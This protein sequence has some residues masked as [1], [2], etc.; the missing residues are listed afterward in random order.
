MQLR[1]LHHHTAQDGPT[2]YSANLNSAY[3]IIRTGQLIEEARRLHGEVAADVVLSACDLGFC[4]RGELRDRALL[5]RGEGQEAYHARRIDNAIDNLIDDHF[6][7]HLRKAHF[8]EEHDVRR[9]VE[10][11]ILS[12]MGIAKL[13]GTKAKADHQAA[14][15]RAY[16]EAISTKTA[17]HGHV[18]MQ[19]FSQRQNEEN[20]KHAS[21]SLANGHASQVNTLVQP[22]LY[23]VVE[24]AQIKVVTDYIRPIRGAGSA[25]I[26]ECVVR[27]AS[28]ANIWAIPETASEVPV[29]T[30]NI[31]ELL[32]NVNA[33]QHGHSEAHPPITNGTASNADA[34]H[35]DAET[36]E[37]VE[38]DDLE[39]ELA[40][41]SETACNCWLKEEPGSRKYVVHKGALDI[42]VRKEETLRLLDSR[43]ND[44]GPRILRILIDK[45]KLEERTLQ[46]L[47]LLDAKRLRQSLAA[48]KQMGYVELQ[49]VPRNPTRQPN[50]TVFLWAYEQGRVA[51]LTLEH[52]YTAMLRLLQLL[53]LERKKIHSTLTKVERE[54]VKGREEEVL[55][56]AEYTVLNRFRRVESWIWAEMQRLDTSVAILRD[57]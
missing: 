17:D 11:K 33:T 47:G 40:L 43:L 1:L 23:K 39:Y 49:E 50:M 37:E 56:P 57:T 22:N 21:S 34:S 13:S 7:T 54:D 53:K 24:L 27:A 35:H 36:N 29:H 6:L 28:Y 45:G 20:G 8:A 32:E 25:K 48:L 5:F 19:Y 2:V 12:P 14:V 10:L 38:I 9:D 30:L 4:T 55:G 3:D 18:N 44:P 16:F 31:H 42:W 51:T 26:A 46:E 41:L 15:D 52:M